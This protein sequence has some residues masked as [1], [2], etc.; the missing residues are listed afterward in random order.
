MVWVVTVSPDGKTVAS[1]SR[2]GFVRLWEAETG[3]ML[4][5]WDAQTVEPPTDLRFLARGD[6]LFVGLTGKALPAHIADVATGKIVWKHT[7]GADPERTKGGSPSVHLSPDGSILLESWGNGTVRA[8]DRATGTVGFDRKLADGGRGRGYRKLHALADGKGFL[9]APG[10]GAGVWEYST[11]T[12]DVIRKYD[13]GLAAPL[14]SVSADGRY[15]AAFESGNGHDP[16]AKDTV[17]VWDRR[18]NEKVCRTVRRFPDLFCV[19][20]SPDGKTFAVGCTASEANVVLL[21]TA[22]GSEVRRFPLG[23]YC[24]CLAFAPDGRTLLAGDNRGLLTRWDVATGKTLSPVPVDVPDTVLRAGFVA[25]GRQ[26]LTYGDSV[27]WW[28]ADTGKPLRS[29]ADPGF[30]HACSRVSPDGK[31]LAFL[32]GDRAA[33]KR[34]SVRLLDLATGTERVL[35]HRLTGIPA[36]L[37]FSPDGTRLAVPGR[38]TPNVYVLDVT[39]G[40]LVH[41]LKDHRTYLD[42]AEF[43]P[44]GKRIVSFGS[45]ANANGDHEIRVWDAVS[46]K[47]LHKLP[48]VRGSAFAVAFAP[49]GRQLVSVGGDPGRTNTKGEIHV[50]DLESGK[51]VRVWDGHKERV[52]CVAVSPDGRSIVTGSLDRTLRLWDLATGRLRYEFAGHRAYVTSVAFAPDGRRF[53]ACSIDAPGYVW[54]LY[55]HLTAK[56]APLSADDFQKVWKDLADADPAVGFRAV[57]RLAAGGDEAVRQLREVLKPVPTADAATV[58]KWIADLGSDRFAVREHAAAELA[59]VADQVRPG[60]RKALESDVTAE[61]RERV[62]RLQAAADGDEPEYRRGRRACEALEAIGTN[63]ARRLAAE[64]AK[65]AAGARLTEEARGSAERLGRRP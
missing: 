33:P 2:G 54:D 56:P 15:F 10:P 51:L 42:H 44:D 11:A 59:K 12:G 3:R 18:K 47:L 39:T 28:D 9:L 13:V 32:T 46:G 17:V 34:S 31:A 27:G 62:T 48:P 30:I 65:G 45:E 6:R 43:S 61:A 14:L 60:L 37:R 16:D 52:T 4:R 55:G 29:V 57:C 5:S 24:L 40:N 20:F 58:A 25:G 7:A 63:E 1:A 50:W 38:F 26:V 64:L 19:E 49:D 8:F 23:A 35:F 22:D 21:N 41:E 53:V 36:W